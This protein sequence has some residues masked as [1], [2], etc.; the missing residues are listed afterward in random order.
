[1]PQI[2]LTR[3]PT[4]VT[5]PSSRKGTC[6]GLL[7]LFFHLC[8]ESDCRA[9]ARKNC[10]NVLGQRATTCLHCFW[11]RSVFSFFNYDRKFI[12]VI[13]LTQLGMVVRVIQRSARRLFREPRQQNTGEQYFAATFKALIST[14]GSSPVCS[15]VFIISRGKTT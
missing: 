5:L 9:C 11:N 8:S 6:E 13:A 3:N 15:Y 7:T 14:L 10:S 12:A 1:M 4:F 2:P